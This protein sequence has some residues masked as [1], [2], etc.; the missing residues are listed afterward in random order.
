MKEVERSHGD[1][2]AG[3]ADWSILTRY[4]EDERRRID[5]FK[6]RPMEIWGAEKVA[7]P[8]T[9][10]KIGRT[11]L[12]VMNI[13]PKASEKQRQK[14]AR[15]MARQEYEAEEAD[16]QA[17]WEE[18]ERRREVERVEREQ[19]MQLQKEREDQMRLEQDFVSAM[20]RYRYNKS[21]QYGA[22]RAQEFIERDFNERL[23]TL[24]DL[25]EQVEQENP[26]VEKRF[27][28]YEDSEIPVYDLK[29]YPFAMMSHAIDYKLI[30]DSNSNWIG[31]KTAGHVVDDPNLW[32]QSQEKVE[33]MREG[34]EARGNTISAS[35]V[36][37]EANFD[38]RVWK[39]SGRVYTC[40]GFEHLEPDSV[41][42]A[43]TQDAAST[44]NFG[45]KRPDFGVKDAQ[46]VRRLESSVRSYNEVVLRRYGEDGQ[47]R[48][49]DYIIAQN[50]LITDDMMRHAKFFNIPIVNIEEAP[51]RER[52]N[53]EAWELMNNLSEDA[54]YEDIAKAL[55]RV[56]R[57]GSQRGQ[58]R[59]AEEIGEGREKRF[60]EAQ[61]RLAYDEMSG[62]MVA[63]EEL[64]AGKRVEFIKDE[65][66]KM[67]QDCQRVTE[68]GREYRA[69]DDK[70]EWM[71]VMLQDMRNKEFI[72]EHS[73]YGVNYLNP[74][75]RVS[76][77]MK[78]RG[79]E[80]MD[81]IETLVL[82]DEDDSGEYEKFEKVV[83]GYLAAT[84]ENYDKQRGV[85]GA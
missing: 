67:A 23:T 6:E 46:A 83:R 84:R 62:R 50:G 54:L 35:Y 77:K 28:N 8:T 51:Y 80:P 21:R 49:P 29:G 22:E 26:E 44:N 65:L 17:R 3:A 5:A 39:T 72:N 75:N 81:V 76:V 61:S 37:S 33:M 34:A 12:D 82:E 63:L 56:N 2:E 78:L 19:Q 47:P 16:R 74:T 25:D 38:T 57:L 41:L 32:M 55:H 13:H 52:Q 4:A 64:E 9:L 69:Q 18:E 36:N 11:V 24:A 71:S 43:S 58:V 53:R 85:N 10:R 79:S 42:L 70:V 40:Y 66:E 68:A 30:N 45:D 31:V 1:R 59:L 48:L 60:I 14:E 73:S 7:P 20:D 15:Y 27:V